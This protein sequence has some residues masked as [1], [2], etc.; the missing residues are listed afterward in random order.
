MCDASVWLET[1]IG[2]IE[3]AVTFSFIG[4]L[5][6]SL[7]CFGW[8]SKHTCYLFD[9]REQLS[10]FCSLRSVCSLCSLLCC[11]LCSL[12]GTYLDVIGW[13]LDRSTCHPNRTAMKKNTQEL[14]KVPYGFTDQHR[15]T[16][17][18]VFLFYFR[19]QLRLVVISGHT[20]SVMPSIL[21]SSA[22]SCILYHK[23]HFV[24]CF[25]SFP[26]AT[27]LLGPLDANTTIILSLGLKERKIL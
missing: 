27:T 11:S 21:V 1:I 15:R 6:S 25:L 8:Q 5:I 3:I 23:N 17:K 13:V 24:C 9:V 4:A 7:H 10:S 18:G 19:I 12:C 26:L 20:K 16:T 14:F 2:E 22:L